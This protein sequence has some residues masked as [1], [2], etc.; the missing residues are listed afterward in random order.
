MP[1]TAPHASALG[2]SRKGTGH[3]RSEHR[4]SRKDGSRLALGWLPTLTPHRQARETKGGLMRTFSWRL[5]PL[6]ES[7]FGD[8]QKA[9]VK[10]DQPDAHAQRPPSSRPA[11]P[12]HPAPHGGPACR[13]T[14]PAAP[15]IVGVGGRLLPVQL[16]HLLQLPRVHLGLRL[17]VGKAA[18]RLQGAD[19][20]LGRVAGPGQRVLDLFGEPLWAG[21]GRG[22]APRQTLTA[23]EPL[24]LFGLSHPS[25]PGSSVW[26]APGMT[27][28]E[29]AP[30]SPPPPVAPLDGQTPAASLGRAPRFRFPLQRGGADH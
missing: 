15:H 30:F 4:T 11:P 17:L 26:G 13:G 29:Q 27:G 14:Y 10:G 2:L 5:C 25:L 19:G 7:L 6:S 21:G 22:G 18:D 23:P 3:V 16:V 20:L 1:Q 24:G 9:R 8:W 12:S 28:Y